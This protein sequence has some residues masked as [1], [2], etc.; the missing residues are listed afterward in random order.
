M[1][2]ELVMRRLPGRLSIATQPPV[3][4]IVSVDNSMI[5][6]APYGPVELQPGE[7]SV[8]VQADR[9]LPFADVINMVGLGREELLSVQL[10]RRW[11]NVEFNSEPAAHLRPR[12]GD[13]CVFCSYGTVK[14]PPIQAD[15][16]CV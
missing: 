16:G 13:C 1:T 12:S 2:I 7:H 3:D 5:G 15:S 9:Y 14:C 11:S 6:K 4:A 8:S 10:V